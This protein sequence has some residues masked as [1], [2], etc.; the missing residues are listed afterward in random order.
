MYRLLFLFVAT[1]IACSPTEDEEDAAAGGNIDT[2]GLVD[3]TEDDCSTDST[4][5]AADC[6]TCGWRK[7]DPGTLVSTG[8][9]IGD[10]IDNI[11]MVDQCGETI[12]IW[13]FY[14]AY[15]VLYMT[16]AW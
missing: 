3:V 15:H 10:V 13:D 5:V 8:S 2:D 1:A 11:A 7:N 9:E 6:Y 4:D 14:G 16:A 12:P